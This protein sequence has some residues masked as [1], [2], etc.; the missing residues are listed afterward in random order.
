MSRALDV[1]GFDAFLDDQH[2]HISAAYKEIEQLQ[3]EYQGAYTRFKAEHDQT[4]YALVDKIEAGAN[5][6]GKS[7]SA[8]IEARAGEEQPLIVQQIADLASQLDR[9][10][11]EADNVLARIQQAIAQRREMNPKLN[12]REEQLK[13]DVARQQQTLNELNTQISQL[14]RGL[15]VI[16]HPVKIFTLDRERWKILGRLQ[17][18]ED[19]LHKVRLDW[20]NL[21]E[22]T[23]KDEADWK[24]QW[25]EKTL[26]LSQLRQQQ[27]YLSQNTAAEARHRATVYVIDNL[28]TLPDASEAAALQPMIDLN[29]QTD[30]FQAALGSV[31]GILGNL[32]GMQ[33]GL[34]RF[35]ASLRSLAAE[36]QQ[37]SD[38]LAP[39]HFRLSDEALAFGQTWEDLIARTQDEKTLAAHPAD[40]VTAMES[41]M[42]ERLSEEHI[43]HFFNSLGATLDDA[44]RSWKSA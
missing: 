40:F 31:S 10:Q 22:R 15:G 41:F 28:K 19:E 36:Q 12:E 44:T 18:L 14:S 5:G 7:L 11:A 39:L 37:H 30:D 2:S 43:T 8:Q 35:K 33:E 1:N 24:T 9:L 26:Q 21:A 17:Q 29:I 16:R 13:S 38:Y 25:Q 23:T 32:T 20:K 3:A 34:R 6:T 42:A 4:L 27:D